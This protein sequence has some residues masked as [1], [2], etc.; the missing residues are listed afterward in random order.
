[1]NE[2]ISVCKPVLE[3][4]EEKYV[5]DALRSG[6]LTH[7]GSY[8]RK[9]E[10]EFSRYVGRPALATS[11][12]TAAL[13]L[14]LLSLGIGPGDEVIVPDLTFGATASVVLAVGAKPVLVDVTPNATLDPDKIEIT[15]K[16]AAIIP[17]HLYGEDAGDFSKFGV[18]VIEDACE[19]LGLTKIRGDIACFSFYANKIITTGEGGMIAGILGRAEEWRNGGFDKDYYH[20]IPGLNYRMTNLQAALGL[21]QL[22]RIEDLARRRAAVVAQYRE[23]LSGFGKWLFVVNTRNPKLLASVLREHGIDSRPVFHPLHKMEPFAQLGD[24]S[25]S[26]SIWESGL[27]LPTGPHLSTDE[28]NRVIEVVN[29]HNVI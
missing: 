17:V 20:E 1:M 14:A 28:V 22:E 19:S 9:F 4:N 21:A 11:S 27:C 15:S 13:H 24:F 18:P 6:W 8:E 5:L 10:E 12:G 2:P 26:V 16:T 23:H 7:H 3:G 25:N 29:E